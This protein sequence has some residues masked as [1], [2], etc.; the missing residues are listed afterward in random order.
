MYINY[1]AHQASQFRILSDRQI[2]KVYRAVLE[3]LNRIGVN[4][5]NAETRDLFAR[6][7]ALELAHQNSVAPNDI[8]RIRVRTFEAAVKLSRAHPQNTEQAQYNLTYPVAAA[9][10]DGELGGTSGATATHT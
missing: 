2:E 8:S 7:G 6:A 3:C 9:L 10:I 1:H 5:L 4:V